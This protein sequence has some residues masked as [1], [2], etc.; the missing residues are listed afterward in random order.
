VNGYIG[1][2]II[3]SED[4]TA[5]KLADQER[6]LFVSL[7]QSSRDFIGMCD[8]QFTPFF[9]NAAGLRMVGLGS[10]DEAT[11]T[12]VKEFFFPE[13]Q[14][15]IMNEFLRRRSRPFAP[16]SRKGRKSAFRT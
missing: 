7:A 15:F 13:D 1:G 4:I 5:W 2:I 9:V 3:Y 16:R 11:R 14:A 8:A 10:L 6:Q 12:P